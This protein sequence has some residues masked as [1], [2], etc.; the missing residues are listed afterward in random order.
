MSDKPTGGPAFPRPNSTAPNGE[1][2]WAEDGMSLRDWFAGQALALGGE[3]FAGIDD[4]QNDPPNEAKHVAF[5]A[6]LIADA[7]IAER[8]K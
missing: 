1:N 6:Y 4:H 3:F 8:D 5:I 2:S 7:M